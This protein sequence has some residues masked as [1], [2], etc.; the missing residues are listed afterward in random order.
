MTT[1]IQ[2]E[3]RSLAIA[4]TRDHANPTVAVLQ[5]DAVIEVGSED[6]PPFA[7]DAHKW[8]ILHMGALTNPI[9]DLREISMQSQ[10]FYAEL[11]DLIIEYRPDGLAA[12]NLINSDCVSAMIGIMS[13]MPSSTFTTTRGLVFPENRSTY[14]KPHIEERVEFS[15]LYLCPVPQ[16]NAILIA[17]HALQD[18]VQK[19]FGLEIPR[20]SPR[21]F[22]SMIRN[23][24]GTTKKG[25][26]RPGKRPERLIRTTRNANS[27]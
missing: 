22:K 20:I 4:P 13:V 5:L 2:Q 21:E 24:Y 23:Y 1:L 9:T 14:V 12:C 10:K 11:S 7:L 6:G 8:S 15:P 25:A 16:E 3:R 18:G 17:S 26:S 27:R 19:R